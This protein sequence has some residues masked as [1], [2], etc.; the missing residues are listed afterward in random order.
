MKYYESRLQFL[1]T[2]PDPNAPVGLNSLI[3]SSEPLVE[4]P[5]PKPKTVPPPKT[6]PQPNKPQPPRPQPGTGSL[7]PKRLRTMNCQGCHILLQYPEGTKIIRCPKWSVVSASRFP[8]P[9]S[10]LLAPRP[11]L[12]STKF[13]LT[14]F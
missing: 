7:P 3:K 14:D 5:K 2:P 6:V 9:G 4:Q 13:L 8:P 11:W 10:L 12:L 1:Q